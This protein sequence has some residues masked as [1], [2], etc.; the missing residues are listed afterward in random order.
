MFCARTSAVS[1][2]IPDPEHKTPD[3]GSLYIAQYDF[4]AQVCGS[5][6]MRFAILLVGDGS[7]V[8]EETTWALA[9][10]KIL[11]MGVRIV[12]GRFKNKD[13]PLI[14]ELASRIRTTLIATS[15]G[16]PFHYCVLG[17]VG[18]V[19]GDGKEVHTI[20]AVA[21]SA[22]VN[23][24]RCHSIKVRTPRVNL[25]G[26]TKGLISINGNGSNRRSGKKQNRRMGAGERQKHK[27]NNQ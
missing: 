16:S 1:N 15:S 11:K 20:M 18:G 4:H 19:R 22:Y 17:D 10:E 2:L 12:V 27:K 14:Q 6:H 13:F 26:T 3:Q 8:A 21:S 5:I 9:A 24:P 7:G 23:F 25:D